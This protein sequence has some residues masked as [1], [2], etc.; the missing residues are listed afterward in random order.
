MAVFWFQKGKQQIHQ[1][2]T[3]QPTSLKNE[4]FQSTMTKARKTD[5]GKGSNLLILH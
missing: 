2:P 1:L 3:R 5:D 4:T